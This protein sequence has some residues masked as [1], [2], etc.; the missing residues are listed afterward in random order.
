MLHQFQN[1]FLSCLSGF[2]KNLVSDRKFKLPTSTHCLLHTQQQACCFQRKLPLYSSAPQDQVW[3]MTKFKLNISEYQVRFQM[4]VDKNRF[5]F[6]VE[7]DGTEWQQETRIYNKLGL[8]IKNGYLG[9][10]HLILIFMKVCF[11]DLADTIVMGCPSHPLPSQDY[12]TLCSGK[13]SFNHRGKYFKLLLNNI[14]ILFI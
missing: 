11:T 5:H 9:K 4:A 1:L 10:E 13:A 14:F 6:G 7:I 2:F 3:S 8:E 12:A